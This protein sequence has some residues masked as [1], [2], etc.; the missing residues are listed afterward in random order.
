MFQIGRDLPVGFGP[1][2][3]PSGTERGR[4][5]VEENGETDGDEDSTGDQRPG[6]EKHA[7]DGDCARLRG[8]TVTERRVRLTTN[9]H[10]VAVASRATASF[11]SDITP[12]GGSL[13]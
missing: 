8:R 7:D 10:V 13:S 4:D 5:S 3:V 9:A 12:S 6:D 1:F 11:G 2:A